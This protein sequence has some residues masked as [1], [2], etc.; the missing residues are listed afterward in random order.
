V[1]TADPALPDY[2]KAP[3][4]S[5]GGNWFNSPPL[6]MEKLGG[7]VVLID[8]WTYSCINC[9][10][11]LPQLEAWDA[12]YRK[13]GLAIVGVHTPEFA[14]EADASNVG[15]A[16]QSFGIRYPVALDPDHATWTNYYNQY[17]PAH[18]LIDRD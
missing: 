17:W 3:E 16:V 5:G 15:R 4:L 18:Y 10:R 9:L 7:T 8:F 1:Q 12:K 14:F 6:T 13:D 2:G 11:T